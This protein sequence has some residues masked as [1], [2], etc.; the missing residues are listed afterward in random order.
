VR[1]ATCSV[2]D[3]PHRVAVVEWHEGAIRW[4]R[5][6]VARPVADASPVSAAASPT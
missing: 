2:R 6:L 3:V 5:T 4:T 1:W